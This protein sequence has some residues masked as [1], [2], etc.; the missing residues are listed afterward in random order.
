MEAEQLISPSPNRKRRWYQF[1]LRTLIIVVTVLAVAC[2]YVGWQARIVRKRQDYLRAY[3]HDH[4]KNGTYLGLADGDLAQAPTGIRL[5]L[6]D[7]PQDVVWLDSKSGMDIES[8][9]ALFPEA[10]ITQWP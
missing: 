2:A 1:S 10:D 6:G 7:K 9:A 5:W 4:A 8:L 3:A